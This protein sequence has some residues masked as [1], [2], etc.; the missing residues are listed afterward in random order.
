MYEDRARL[1]RLSVRSVHSSPP[2]NGAEP[3]F[4]THVYCDQTAGCINVP[5]GV[6]V[7]LASGHIVLDGAQLPPIFGPCLLWPN[8]WMDHDATWY[9]GRPRPRR[10][11]VRL[12]SNPFPHKGAQLPPILR[13]CLLW[14]NG[15]MHQDTAWYGDRPQHSRHYVRW[16][17]NSPSPK[18]AEPPIFG[19]CSL[20][21]NGWMLDRLRCNFVWR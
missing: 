9:G 15:C 2:P 11:C 16:G 14:R 21:T 10:H 3:Q 1:R 8:G 7:G 18:G 4:W 12:E 6:E 17:P 5:L 13:P 19:P 20:W